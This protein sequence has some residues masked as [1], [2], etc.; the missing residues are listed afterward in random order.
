MLDFLDLNGI[1]I[2]K[3][4]PWYTDMLLNMLFYY[5]LF[6]IDSLVYS[7]KDSGFLLQ[8]LWFPSW[9]GKTQQAVWCGLTKKGEKK[10]T[11]VNTCTLYRRTPQKTRSGL[12]FLGCLLAFTSHWLLYPCIIYHDMVYFVVGVCNVLITLLVLCYKVHGSHKAFQLFFFFFFF[13]PTYIGGYRLSELW[14][15][16]RHYCIFVFKIIFFKCDQT[17]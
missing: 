9:S 6:L 4:K 5:W 12:F 16:W 15:K 13:K 8:W 10:T 14:P 11:K 17:L 2:S 1:W 3:I 7:G